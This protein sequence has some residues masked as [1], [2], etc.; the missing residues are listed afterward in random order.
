[1]NAFTYS[2]L[3]SV[4]LNDGLQ[5]IGKN[6][7]LDT[8]IEEIRIPASVTQI[9]DNAFPDSLKTVYLEKYTPKVFYST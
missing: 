2:G 5:K 8:N 4:I 1:M 6:V 7:F 3:K 9:G